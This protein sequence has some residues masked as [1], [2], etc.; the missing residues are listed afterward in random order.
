[1]EWGTEPQELLGIWGCA[2]GGALC[3]PPH[4]TATLVAPTGI[5][6]SP[7]EGQYLLHKPKKAQL[8]FP[9]SPKE[10]RPAR[11]GFPAIREVQHRDLEAH[12]AQTCQ[13]K[14]PVLLL[15]QGDLTEL[16][17]F[18]K[19]DP[20]DLSFSNP[21]PRERRTRSL[22]SPSVCRTAQPMVHPVRSSRPLPE[23]KFKQLLQSIHL[24]K[25]LK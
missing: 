4:L 20:P 10:M 8:A 15:R 6:A 17:L 25:G 24:S 21:V 12:I 14:G 1:M 13:I 18:V 23:L 7:Q 16:C 19:H 2:W 11:P 9:S 5:G 22:L 3:P